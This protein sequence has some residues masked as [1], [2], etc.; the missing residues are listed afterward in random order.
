MEE[1]LYSSHI[2][3]IGPHRRDI[4]ILEKKQIPAQDI[5]LNIC[6]NSMG[7]FGQFAK[8]SSRNSIQ[9]DGEGNPLL[10]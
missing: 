7:H 10:P 9:S 2:A 8:L 4:G 6:S 3:A 5:E 1:F